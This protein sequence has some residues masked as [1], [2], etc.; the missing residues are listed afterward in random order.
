MDKD[1]EKSLRE[2]MRKSQDLTRQSEELAAKTE[3]LLAQS[4]ERKKQE[5]ASGRKKLGSS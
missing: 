4:R 5:G 3:A 2:V 1:F